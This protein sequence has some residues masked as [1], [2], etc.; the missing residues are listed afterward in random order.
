MNSLVCSQVEGDFSILVNI[1]IHKVI[2]GYCYG[3]MILNP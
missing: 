3:G 1:I 2:N